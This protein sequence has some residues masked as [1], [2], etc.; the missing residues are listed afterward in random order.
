MLDLGLRA[1]VG[2]G[3]SLRRSSNDLF[4]AVTAL[5]HVRHSPRNGGLLQFTLVRWEGAPQLHSSPFAVKCANEVA[6]SISK[7]ARDVQTPFNG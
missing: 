3:K 6:D 7:S 1:G 5:F 2:L 4:F